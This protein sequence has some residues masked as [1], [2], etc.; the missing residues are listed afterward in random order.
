MKVMLDTNMC[1]YLIKQKPVQVLEKF[2][3]YNLGDIGVSSI[4][5]A[6][7]Q[8]RVAKSQ[9]QQQNQKALTQFLAPLEIADFGASAA[10]KYGQIRAELE[11]LGT[12]IG[13]NDLLIAG[14]ALSLDVVLV[15]NN[16]REF[17]RV[18]SLVIENWAG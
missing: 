9:R 5:V 6:E 15:T 7:L 12:L 14:H 3:T 2:Q 16:E 8:Y 17:S 4:T 10:L 13:G 1:I 18:P 11:R